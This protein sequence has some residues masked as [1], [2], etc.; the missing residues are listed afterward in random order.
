[1][2]R[3]MV[4]EDEKL[5]LE[6]LCNLLIE[7]GRVEIIG[8]FWNPAEAMEQITALRPDVVFLD[9]EMP[10]ITGLE[11]ADKVKALTDDT[12]I[13]FTT[14]YN[15]YA[16]QAF[17]VNAL[18]YLLKPIMANDLMKTLNRLDKAR[19]KKFDNLDRMVEPGK[20][21]LMNTFGG[22]K[23]WMES[24]KEPIHWSTEKCSELLAYFAFYEHD[25]GLSKWRLIEALWPNCN[26]EKGSINLRSTVSRL[27]KTL[28]EH[29]AQIKIVSRPYGYVLQGQQ[30]N[31][32][33]AVLRE[34]ALSCKPVGPENICEYEQ[35]LETYKGALF[36]GNDFL[37]AEKLKAHYL[38][39]YV[40]LADR[41]LR[42]H[43]MH[44][45]HCAK[46]LPII[47]KWLEQDP[48]NESAHEIAMRLYFKIGGRSALSGYFE[49]LVKMYTED[50]EVSLPEQLKAVHSSLIREEALLLPADRQ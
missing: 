9:I 16:L 32:D 46:A 25:E 35:I 36:E 41:V 37:W 29:S 11:L 47:E 2:I 28:A 49:N 15:D 45:N 14:A 7:D 18:N 13:V 43:L 44:A 1:M 50:E 39:Y 27:N 10:E 3:A 31:T 42:Y 33:A 20:K 23:V 22:L 8:A 6:R 34:A 21:V 4:V 5:T 19:S 38:N 30:I 40:L 17:R 12:E 24:S 48:Y 26:P